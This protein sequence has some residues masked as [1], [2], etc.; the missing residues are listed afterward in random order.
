MVNRSL[1]RMA[2]PGRGTSSK[3]LRRKCPLGGGFKLQRA[4]PA[5]CRKPDTWGPLRLK[6]RSRRLLCTAF[7]Y[8]NHAAFKGNGVGRSGIAK[9]DAACQRPGSKNGVCKVIAG[10]HR[11]SIRPIKCGEDEIGFIFHPPA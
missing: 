8:A 4:T 1:T 9:L 6:K 3:A 5:I 10:T 7:A 2:R 11:A